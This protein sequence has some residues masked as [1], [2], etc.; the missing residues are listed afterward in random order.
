MNRTA[1]GL[2]ASSAAAILLVYLTPVLVAQEDASRGRDQPAAETI[3]LFFRGDDFGYTHASN[4]A[5]SRALEAGLL[6]SA[7]VLVLGAWAA[8]T[9]DILRRWPETSVGVHLALTSEWNRLRWR[10]ASD[11]EKIP[12]LLAPDGA[13]FKNFRRTDPRVQGRLAELPAAQ[14]AEMEAL[15][16][17]EPP[18]P[19]DAATELRAQVRLARALGLRVDYLD[20]HMGVACQGPLREILLELAE[21]LCV[22]VPELGLMRHEEIGIEWTGEPAR[23]EQALEDLLRSLQPGLYRLV[24]HIAEDAG[25]LRNVDSFSGDAEAARRLS[26]LLALESPRIRDAIAE[27]AIQLVRIRDLWNYET[28][29]LR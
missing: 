26:Q 27:R 24:V 11:P 4:D 1:S 17:A 12:T 13:L 20:C 3:R 29:E 5:L 18:N 6:G 8:E 7:S 15:L 16:S 28:C 10:P 19:N 25:E 22:P 14:R 2:R 23:D 9:S 21:E